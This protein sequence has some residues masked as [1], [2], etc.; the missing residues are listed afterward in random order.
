MTEKQQ[1]VDVTVKTLFVVLLAFLYQYGGFEMKWLRRYLAP[2]IWC[3][4]GAVYTKSWKTLPQMVFM[5]A[6]L[7]IGYGGDLLW[8]KIGKRALYGMANGI[9]SSGNNL[10]NSKWLLV[11]TQIIL[12]IGL[13]IVMG[14]WNPLPNA[15]IEEFFL[16]FMIFFIPTIS[17]ERRK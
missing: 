3:V 4:A 1:M 13:Y 15:R 14:V 6:S 8:T 9:S 5:F 11:A 7:S 10:F 17:L 2:F 12:L 16:G